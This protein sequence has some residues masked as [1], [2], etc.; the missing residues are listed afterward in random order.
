MH[1]SHK[2]E[3][4]F[5]PWLV[6]FPNMQDGLDAGSIEYVYALMAK[7]AGIEMPLFHVVPSGEGPGYF[8]TKRFDRD[9]NKRLHM[10]T[11]CGLL[12]A[13]FRSPSLDYKD[14]INLTFLLTRDIRE[15][16]KMFRLAVFTV[17]AHNRDT[18]QRTSAF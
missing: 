12:H 11:A 17:L 3:K 16:E 8:A 13:D 10:H 9:G 4:G 18:M 2:L 1:G 6:N 14:L 7:D 5:E 15:A